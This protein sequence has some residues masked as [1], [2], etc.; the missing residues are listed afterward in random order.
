[1]TGAIQTEM[2]P[3][4]WSIP[5]AFPGYLPRL[6]DRVPV[7]RYPDRMDFNHAIMPTILNGQTFCGLNG[8][9]GE[10]DS[11]HGPHIGNGFA[12]AWY[13]LGVRCHAAS[14]HSNLGGESG[15]SSS[16]LAISADSQTTSLSK[17]TG[18]GNDPDLAAERIVLGL[19]PISVAATGRLSS[20]SFS[21]CSIVG[22][23]HSCVSYS[24]SFN[25]RWQG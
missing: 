12:G 6:D 20:D 25:K 14:P 9:T 13:E 18:D 19:R 8:F 16:Q 2:F 5:I 4:A 22:Y 3:R 24:N 11:N 21:M 7:F 23:F 15:E 17:E 10:I 1:M